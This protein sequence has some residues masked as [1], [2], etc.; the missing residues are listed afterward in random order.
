MV[1]LDVH[2]RMESLQAKIQSRRLKRQASD[3]SGSATSSPGR[4]TQTSTLS[5]VV[6]AN[7]R[8]ETVPADSQDHMDMDS[9]LSS[10]SS[11]SEL[12]A[13]I[14]ARQ[15]KR[16][17]SRKAAANSSAGLKNQSALDPSVSA[18]SSSESDLRSKEFTYK[19]KVSFPAG[20][21]ARTEV[22]NKLEEAIESEPANNDQ[23]N[24]DDSFYDKMKKQCPEGELRSAFQGILSHRSL[25][26][27][28]QEADKIR[29]QLLL[30]S[31]DDNLLDEPPKDA[32]LTRRCSGEMRSAAKGIVSRNS[33]TDFHSNIHGNYRRASSSGEKRPAVKAHVRRASISSGEE[34]SARRGIGREKIISNIICNAHAG[35]RVSSLSTDDETISSSSDNIES[36]SVKL[37]EMES[38]PAL[39][40]LAEGQTFLGISMLV[41]MYS[42][43]REAVRMGLTR[44]NMQ[45]ID[46]NSC[47]SQYT[48][49]PKRAYLN[50]TKTA[51][52]IIR[53]VIDELDNEDENDA[54][55]ELLSG[56]DKEYERRLVPFCTGYT[57]LLAFVTI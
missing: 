57:V 44:V 51:G 41:Y 18:T 35:R 49:H 45:D 30:D 15:M 37:T 24:S 22:A 53:V 14:H 26:K 32:K 16:Q 5:E 34:S 27:F 31:D 9:S 20:T 2:Q 29:Q 43:L 54:N 48:S 40:I 39:D 7:K 28:G 8:Q 17:A 11:D 25:I 19:P 55:H 10:E 23:S 13:K 47:Q 3:A 36:A 12:H 6:A 21:T 50:K 52:S 33:M 38:A 4:V 1:Y 56:E 42:H 46:V